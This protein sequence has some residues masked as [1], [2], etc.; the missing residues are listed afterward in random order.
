MLAQQSPRYIC[1]VC[2]AAQSR[3]G[4]Y[5]QVTQIRR[6]ST[7]STEPTQNSEAAANVD[8]SQRRIP[9]RELIE[10]RK[11]ESQLS[12]AEP[13]EESFNPEEKANGQQSLGEKNDANTGESEKSQELSKES[14][15]EKMTPPT[16]HA[17]SARPKKFSMNL[18][19]KIQWQSNTQKQPHHNQKR[20]P[21]SSSTSTTQQSSPTDSSTSTPSASTATTESL[22]PISD[23]IQSRRSKR[24]ET[25]DI[26]LPSAPTTKLRTKPLRPTRRVIGSPD[27]VS[28]LARAR[29][30][31]VTQTSSDPKI[32]P[33]D[34]I[35]SHDAFPGTAVRDIVTEEIQASELDHRDRIWSED[36]K[37]TPVQPKELRPVPT[38][39]HGLDRVLFK[40]L[41]LC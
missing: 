30:Y 35:N 18:F 17:P 38:L 19:R 7:Q 33:G 39:E 5:R 3:S 36:I 37:M 4:R 40:Y 29:A 28:P 6:L 34:P 8:E 24:L 13:L 41:P 2:L 21:T 26:P 22:T 20:A 1:R 25:P 12:A 14:N 10:R 16:K 27:A 11:L 9:L 31:Q 23:A 15:K 32:H